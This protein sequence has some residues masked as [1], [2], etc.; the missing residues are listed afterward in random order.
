MYGIREEK[1]YVS[2]RGNVVHRDSAYKS[3]SMVKAQ[4]VADRLNN[5]N[6]KEYF[7]VLI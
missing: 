4:E 7:V 2:E 5:K 3:C 6:N 1:G